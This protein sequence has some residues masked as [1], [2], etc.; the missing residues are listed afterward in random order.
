MSDKHPIL[1]ATFLA[2]APWAFMLGAL[3]LSTILC[4]GRDR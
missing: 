2:V 3:P 1:W 4:G